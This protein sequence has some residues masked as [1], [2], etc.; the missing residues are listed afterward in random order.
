M[1]IA[2]IVTGG[3]HPSGRQEIVP[4]LVALVE[5]L[6]RAHDVHAFALRHLPA[7]ATYQLRGATVHDLGRP[8][9]RRSQ[10]VTLKRELVAN[11][12][13]DVVHGY[14]ADPAG[15]LAAAAGRWFNMPSVVTCSSGE[16]TS[17]TG[18]GYGLQRSLK[19]RT[20]VAATCRLATCVH[21]PTH[22]MAALAAAH[23]VS[24]RRIPVGTDTSPRQRVHAAEGPPW[25]VLQ[26][27]SLN[28]VKDQS[29]LIN[30]VALARRTCDVR[31]DLVGEDT[32]GGTLQGEVQALGIADAV[33]FHGFVLHDRLRPF[34]QSAHLYV[35]SSLH[36][37]AGIS[38]LEAA[39]AGLPIVGTRVG[40]VSDWAGRGA[41]DVPPAD[42]AQLADAIV[43]VLHDPAR[44]QSLAAVAHQFVREHDADYTARTLVDLYASLRITP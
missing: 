2:L 23:G 13:F 18:I 24:T 12:P 9:G 15:L 22:Y 44:R 19:A 38:V 34:Y 5:R 4:V 14:W 7:P 6:A 35:Q 25:R 26:V 36:E 33:M 37:A 32:L 21:V 1:K 28:Q 11:G 10:W 30:A 41:E 40:Y 27:A 17:L 31:L 16:F 39:A 3:L 8:E 42:A 43:R 29:T 20:V